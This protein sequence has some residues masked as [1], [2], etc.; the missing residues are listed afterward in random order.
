MFHISGNDVCAILV[1][2]SKGILN[3]RAR[4]RDMNWFDHHV[5]VHVLEAKQTCTG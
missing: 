3:I 4:V 5:V 2:R 1:F